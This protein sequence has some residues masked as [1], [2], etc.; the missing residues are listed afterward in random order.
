M[1]LYKEFVE[2][3]IIISKKEAT[4]QRKASQNIIKLQKH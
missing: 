1:N 2:N 4:F 3:F